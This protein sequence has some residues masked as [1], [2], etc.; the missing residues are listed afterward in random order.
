VSLARIGPRSPATV[1]AVKPLGP[2]HVE[3]SKGRGP[4]LVL[5][6]EGAGS[7]RDWDAFQAELTATGRRVLAYDR[8][9]FGRSPRDTD[10]GRNLFTDDVEDLV[11]LLTYSG[12]GPAHLVGHSD[13]GTVALLAASLHPGLFMSVTAVATH[14]RPDARTVAAVRALGQPAEWA[15]TAVH[16]YERRHGDDWE[17]V[18][19]AWLRLWTDEALTTWDITG[20]LAELRCPVLVVHDRRDPLSSPMHAEAIEAAVPQTQVAWYDTGGHWPHRRER[21]RFMHEL[22]AH[23]SAAEQSAGTE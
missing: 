12:L 6:H 13:G 5:L 9:G 20:A 14:V 4:L 16:S 17:Q 23:L 8:R 11:T 22:E 18:V 15:K 1:R 19:S 2:L 21:T 3:L 10:Y 7:S